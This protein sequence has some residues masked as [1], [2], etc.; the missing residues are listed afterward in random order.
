VTQFNN[1]YFSQ[2]EYGKYERGRERTRE[3]EL[4]EKRRTLSLTSLLS[5]F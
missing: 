4:G 2:E 3:R 1:Y 5:F